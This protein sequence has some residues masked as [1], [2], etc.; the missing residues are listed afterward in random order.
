M[1]TTIF[2]GGMLTNAGFTVASLRCIVLCGVC[3]CIVLYHSR[4]VSYCTCRVCQMY[5]IAR[6]SYHVVSY[7]TECRVEPYRHY[8][9]MV[10]YFFGP[11]QDCIRAVRVRIIFPGLYHDFSGRIERNLWYDLGTTWYDPRSVNGSYSDR[12]PTICYLLNGTGSIIWVEL[13]QSRYHGQRPCISP[14]RW[15]GVEAM[16]QGSRYHT[17]TDTAQPMW[18]Y[19]YPLSHEDNISLIVIL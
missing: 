1:L 11:Y 16:I 9:R 13:Y 5:C 7:H 2:G 10:L 12:N 8:P 15:Y 6:G 3:L 18:W 17:G 19:L 4:F 14:E